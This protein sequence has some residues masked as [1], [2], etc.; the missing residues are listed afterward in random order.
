MNTGRFSSRS[1]AG[2][3]GR[4]GASGAGRSGRGPRGF[5]IAS[6]LPGAGCR[7]G[8]LRTWYPVVA[9]IFEFSFRSMLMGRRLGDGSETTL[10]LSAVPDVWSACTP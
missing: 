4:C 5:G 2:S 9:P 7:T 10:R 8:T 1:T 3:T 6:R